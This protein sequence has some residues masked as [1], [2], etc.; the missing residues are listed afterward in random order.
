MEL[1][2]PF[3]LAAMQTVR[4]LLA[5]DGRDLKTGKIPHKGPLPSGYKLELD[6]TDE[7]DTEHHSHYQ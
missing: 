4:D 5:E 6:V 3:V 2:K 7:F 1:G